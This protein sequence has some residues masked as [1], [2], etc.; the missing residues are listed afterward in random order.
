MRPW[1]RNWKENSDP[2]L[3][4][5]NIHLVAH[6]FK[7]PSCPSTLPFR[8]I[9]STQEVRE[10]ALLNI[11]CIVK[12]YH[13]WCFEVNVGEVLTANKKRGI[14]EDF[15]TWWNLQALNTD[16]YRFSI[17]CYW[18][19]ITTRIFAIDWSSIIN[20][21]RLIDIDWYWLISIVIDYRFH[22]LDTPGSNVSLPNINSKDVT[23][24]DRRKSQSELRANYTKMQLGDANS[25]VFPSLKQK[26]A[27]DFSANHNAW[28]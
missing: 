1:G 7:L 23:Q 26:V 9:M 16:R 11:R 10:E 12:G 25:F 28:Q 2:V 17:D 8:V 24:N 27:Q 15:E 3:N 21:N 22:H 20:N 14:K 5:K 6:V 19:S 4:A 13:L 18:K